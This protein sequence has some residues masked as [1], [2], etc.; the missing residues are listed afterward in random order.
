MY[1]TFIELGVP[2][3]YFVMGVTLILVVLPTFYF[4]GKL[5]YKHMYSGQVY[6]DIY[7]NPAIQVNLKALHLL[8]GDLLKRSEFLEREKALQVMKELEP[9]IVK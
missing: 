3:N 4:I 8:M 2:V 6:P 7:N 9:M 5:H 1:L